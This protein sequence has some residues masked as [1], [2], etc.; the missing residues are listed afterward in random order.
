MRDGSLEYNDNLPFAAVIHLVYGGESCEEPLLY[1][2]K[3]STQL[4]HLE[5]PGFEG[6]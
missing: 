4:V 1:E 5:I 2:G 6:F 3:H